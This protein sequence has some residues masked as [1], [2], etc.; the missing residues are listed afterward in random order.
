MKAQT[1]KSQRCL[2]NIIRVVSLISAF[3]FF[4][5]FS[6]YHYIVFTGRDFFFRS[7]IWNFLE[8]MWNVLEL[9]HIVICQLSVRCN[10][11][12]K[13]QRIDIQCAI[14]HHSVFKHCTS[15]VLGIWGHKEKEI[16]VVVLEF[17]FLS[18]FGNRKNNPSFIL[19]WLQWIQTAKW[20]LFATKNKIPF[21]VNEQSIFDWCNFEYFNRFR[22]AQGKALSRQWNLNRDFRLF[23][24]L[25]NYL[26]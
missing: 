7:L 4:I 1:N 3:L 2:H 9:E 15:G 22:F 25:L 8:K 10:V 18:Y 6:L 20:I 26:Y 17:L 16:I 11:K 12:K 19:M 14:F 23:F 21:Q 13:Q 24:D 5:P